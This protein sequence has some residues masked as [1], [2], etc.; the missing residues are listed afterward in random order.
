MYAHDAFGLL[1]A[2]FAAL[3]PPSWEAARSSRLRVVIWVARCRRDAMWTKR[4]SPGPSA[5]S[6]R[7]SE[8][9]AV[10]CSSGA[11]S[12]ASRPQCSSRSLGQAP[13]WAARRL[14]QDMKYEKSRRYNK[15]STVSPYNAC[16]S[17]DLLSLGFSDHPRYRVVRRITWYGSRFRP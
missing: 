10:H 8:A 4:A 17:S 9:R 13:S 6:R 14:Q 12:S 11:G 7:C 5:S 3:T 16:I 1:T 2:L 15:P